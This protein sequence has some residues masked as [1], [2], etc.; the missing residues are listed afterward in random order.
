MPKLNIDSDDITMQVTGASNF[1]FSGVRPDNLQAL[2]YTLVTIIIDESGSTRDFAD[3]M[4]EM[5][6]AIIKSC[7]KSPRADNIMIRLV[8]FNTTITEVHG[9]RL[10]TTI[11]PSDYKPF[12]PRGMT[13]LYDTIFSTVGATITY[14]KTLYSKD[15]TVNGIVFI[16]TDG[17]DNESR[18]AS[19]LTIGKQCKDLLTSEEIESLLT[20]L[21]GLKNPAD[22]KRHQQE[23]DKYLQKL[24]TEA[25]LTQY[26]DAGVANESN[27]AKL[28]N[29]VSQSISS[30]S[31]SLGS[32]VSGSIAN[33]F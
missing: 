24:K 19:P 16:I 22:D 33:T 31:Q 3:T 10:L 20:I 7:G 25:H 1:H 13:A 23:I 27:L 6:K 18:Y 32:G 17:E 5:V 30:Q 2:E 29:F 21:I 28:A 8:T 14:G 9:F 12:N 15:L 4:L 26:I 11:N